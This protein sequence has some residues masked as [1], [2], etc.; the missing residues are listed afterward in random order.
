[1]EAAREVL[2]LRTCRAKDGRQPLRRQIRVRL[3]ERFGAEG[4]QG[5]GTQDRAHRRHRTD[6]QER[7]VPALQASRR[8]EAMQRHWRV[9]QLPA[10]RRTA[11]RLQGQPRPAR[12]ELH[13]PLG[14][15]SLWRLLHRSEPH[16]AG[17]LLCRLQKPDGRRPAL[18]RDRRRQPHRPHHAAATDA[19]QG[20]VQR[21][22]GA[23]ED[24]APAGGLVRGRHHME[25]TAQSVRALHHQA[26]RR[27]REGCPQAHG[28]LR[29]G[30]PGLRPR[31]LDRLR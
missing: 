11:R 8:T 31:L 22:A 26:R 5:A 20:R 3:R 18:P 15:G 4:K 14:H 24:D 27:G 6:H 9:Q 23:P 17:L 2:C 19:G 10:R 25:Q 21:L 12:G 29:Q 28:L 1:M 30:R 7:R 16:A 13:R